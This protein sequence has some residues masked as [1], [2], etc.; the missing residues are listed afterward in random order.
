M[1]AVAPRSAGA[2]RCS[3]RRQRLTAT[4]G[5]DH[6]DPQQRG[7]QGEV[8][9]FVVECAPSHIA[10]DDPIVHPGM[11]GMSHLHQFF[12]NSRVGADSDY[13]RL[14]GAPTSCDQ[15]L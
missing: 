9:Q 14:V 8:A 11:A 3:V 13:D 10:F 5:D 7:P 4:S 15:P 12:G 1:A 6:P 2:V